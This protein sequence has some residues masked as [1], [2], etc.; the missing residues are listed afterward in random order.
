MTQIRPVATFQP[1]VT[2]VHSIQTEKRDYITVNLT[3]IQSKILRR[4][5][6]IFKS[7]K[8]DPVD[9]GLQKCPIVIFDQTVILPNWFLII[10]T[11]NLRLSRKGDTYVTDL[12]KFYLEV[13]RVLTSLHYFITSK[14]F[15]IQMI[16][17]V[18]IG[19]MSLCIFELKLEPKVLK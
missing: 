1:S 12:F 7:F 13:M 14:W 10:M 4:E 8:K 2:C 17:I 6:K 11:H 15:Q 9:N 18:S 3:K 5:L 16:C 19:L